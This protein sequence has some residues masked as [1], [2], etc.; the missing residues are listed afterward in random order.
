M[1]LTCIACIR[2]QSF[3][4]YTLTFLNNQCWLIF[5]PKQNYSSSSHTRSIRLQHRKERDFSPK[6]TRA[7]EFYAYRN[8]ISLILTTLHITSIF[9]TDLKKERKNNLKNFCYRMR[10]SQKNMIWLLTIHLNEKERKDSSRCEKVVFIY[11]K[12]KKKYQKMCVGIKRKFT[13]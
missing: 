12:Q 9:L 7:T 4:S 11:S 8:I 5:L 13:F 3:S 10:A 6:N 1:S 2:I